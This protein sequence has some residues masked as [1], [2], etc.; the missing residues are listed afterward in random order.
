MLRL[1]E[2]ILGVTLTSTAQ[3]GA[4]PHAIQ[5]QQTLEMWLV[6]LSSVDH[7]E[8]TL[9]F[10]GLEQQQN[11]HIFLIPFFFVL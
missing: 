6:S 7:V 3:I 11:S 10:I 4:V 5:W 1:L 2:H 8:C 9:D